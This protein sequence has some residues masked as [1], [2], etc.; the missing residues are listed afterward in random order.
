[1]YVFEGASEGNWD[2]VQL[3]QQ[4]NSNP[5]IQ[6]FKVPDHDHFSV[7][8]PVTELLASQISAGSVNVT[9]ADVQAMR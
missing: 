8:T 3:M 7:I 4:N 6:F 9:D 2:A 1:M 5:Q